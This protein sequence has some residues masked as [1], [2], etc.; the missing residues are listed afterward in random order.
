MAVTA[1]GPR[2]DVLDM[3]CQAQIGHL[4]GALPAAEIVAA[5]Y[6]HHLRVDPPRPRWPARSIPALL[7]LTA[8][9]IVDAATRARAPSTSPW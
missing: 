2:I 5:L 8:G 1:R 3:V 7:G 9:A 4:G 6:W